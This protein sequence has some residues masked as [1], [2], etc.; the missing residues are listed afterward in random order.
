MDAHVNW[1]KPYTAQML[2]NIL[3]R[4]NESSKILVLSLSCTLSSAKKKCDGAIVEGPEGKW[5]AW[6]FADGSIPKCAFAWESG[7]ES[8]AM[9]MIRSVQTQKATKV[10]RGRVDNIHEIKVPAVASLET[11]SGVAALF[12]VMWLSRGSKRGHH[13]GAKG[14]MDLRR[15]EYEEFMKLRL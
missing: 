9:E 5:M 15:E 11:D 3:E 14:Y 8:E 6:W 13:P 1:D 4:R 12:N 7:M 10:H 2:C